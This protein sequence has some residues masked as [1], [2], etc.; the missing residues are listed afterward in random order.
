ME[1][2]QKIEA[3]STEWQAAAKRCSLSFRGRTTLV[4]AFALGVTALAGQ[5]SSGILFGAAPAW[6]A[7]SEMVI[8]AASNGG[9]VYVP[10]ELG[11]SGVR[12]VS[13]RGWD[14][15]GRLLLSKGVKRQDIQ[16]LLSDRRM[17]EREPLY[18]SLEPR[19]SRV[20]YSK[21]NTLRNR[22]HALEFYSEHESAFIGAERQYGVPRGV[23]LALIQVETACGRNTGDERVFYRLARLASAA[24]PGNIEE[25]FIQKTPI[26]RALTVDR[27]RARAEILQRL[28]LEHVAAT[29]TVARNMDLH[30]LELRGSSAGAIGIPQFL[31]GNVKRF[32]VDGDHDGV[33]DVFTPADAIYSVANFLHSN[34]WKN[35][36]KLPRPAQRR[37]ISEYNRSEPYV[38]TVLTM[39]KLLDDAIRKAS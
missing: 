33:V 4:G 8:S 13:L 20:L 38:S 27:V 17:P 31:P 18:F 22:R 5:F 1:F 21:H 6:A 2:S 3:V 16:E 15:L 14:F 29:I 10:P 34:G 26:V 23:L 9:A 30:P 36:Y 35:G 12:E 25:N 37:V 39:G 19:E 7:P 32:G 28:F 24:E 11:E